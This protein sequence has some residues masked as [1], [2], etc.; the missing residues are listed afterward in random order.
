MC[1][2]W[3]SLETANVIYS[4]VL[5]SSVKEKR[6][7]SSMAKAPD[8]VDVGWGSLSCGMTPSFRKC[9]QQNRN[10]YSWKTRSLRNIDCSQ[11]MQH[12]LVEIIHYKYCFILPTSKH[13]VR[14]NSQQNY[15]ELTWLPNSEGSHGNFKTS[16]KTTKILLNR[17]LFL[18]FT[19][20]VIHFLMSK[21]KQQAGFFCGFD[22]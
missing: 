4:R 11:R 19:W 3:C 12:H 22:Y 17:P 20:S 2:N 14:S 5:D 9:F 7:F 10:F 21:K 18:T 8:R 13:L 15:K 6:V 16:I 1:S